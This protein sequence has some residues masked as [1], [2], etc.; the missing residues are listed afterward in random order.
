MKTTLLFFMIFSLAI[1]ECNSQQN[2]KQTGNI[3]FSGSVLEFYKLYSSLTDPG[4]YV[5]L[6]ENLPDSLP[7]L[8]SLIK[9]QFIHPNAE[10]A[11]YRKQIP[12]ERWNELIKYPTVKSILEGLLYYDSRGIVN[13]RKPEDKLVLGCREYAILL[14]SVLKHR[15]IPARVR[16]GH[17]PYL[18]PGFHASH[19]ICEV[20]NEKEKRW[21]IVDPATGMVDFNRDE[22]DFSYDTW[23]QLQKKEI[24]PGIYGNPGQYTGMVSIVGKVCPDLASLL[25]NEYTIYQYAPILDFAFENKDQ[26]PAEHTEL[27]NTIC[28]LMKSPNADNLSKLQEI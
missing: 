6:Y 1:T 12:E 8:C 9:S 22:F 13:D 11:E 18:I 17:A 27:L 23:F 21:M 10:L 24:D 5:Y 3:Q 20:W 26:M 2:V 16:T 28:E 19:T 7:E 15:D 25:G 4:E 14:A